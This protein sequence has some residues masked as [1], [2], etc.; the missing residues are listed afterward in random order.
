VDMKVAIHQ[1]EHFPY[2][3]FFQKMESCDLFVILD[4]V[5]FSKNNFQNR[6]RFKNSNGIE[7]WFTIPVPSTANSSI[8]NEIIVKND[9]SWKS[10][11]C[12]KLSQNLKV[13][14]SIVY[15]CSDRLIDINMSSINFVREK[16]GI[17]TPLVLSSELSV[18]GN[19]S[20]KLLNL[21][22]AVGATSYLSGQ[23]GLD[24]LNKD[25]FETERI[26]LEIFEPK[27]KDYYTT[28]AHIKDYE[29]IRNIS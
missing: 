6:N 29:S 11:I 13:D 7:E 15:E 4:D 16:L 2:V 24:Y 23:G 14:V 22:K 10:K 19:K 26:E 8:I 25:L 20:N 21:C 18:A 27:I 12:S 3:G 28:L 1:P 17:T 5:K 9:K